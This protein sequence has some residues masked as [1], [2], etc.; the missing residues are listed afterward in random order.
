MFQAHDPLAMLRPVHLPPSEIG[1]SGDLFI[2][3]ALGLVAALVCT[4]LLAFVKRRRHS[5][6]RTALNALKLSR[7]EP[8][9]RRLLLQAKLLRDIVR[10][11][12]GDAAARL[13][14][15]AWHQQLDATFRTTFFTAGEG[16]LYL[17][18]LYQP[19]QQANADEVDSWLAPLIRR[20]RR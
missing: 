7:A 2:A 5:V 12:N 11:I 3:I 9:E 6:R 14:G 1:G 15:D 20:V 8:S 18:S 17:E 10:Q 13:S 4:E 16:R 19:H